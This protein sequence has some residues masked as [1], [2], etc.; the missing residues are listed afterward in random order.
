MKPINGITPQVSGCGNYMQYCIKAS[1]LIVISNIY[2]KSRYYRSPSK[3]AIN[4]LLKT[5]KL[6]YV[7]VGG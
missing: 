5:A 4:H 7:G 6:L 2:L 3:P 1:C